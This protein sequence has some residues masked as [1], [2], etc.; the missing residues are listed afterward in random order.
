[1]GSEIV[2]SVK[3]LCW[4]C[5]FL[6][7]A[8]LAII[9][10]IEDYWVLVIASL[11]LVIPWGIGVRL[12]KPNLITTTIIGFSSLLVIGTFLEIWV[13][14]MVLS[15]LFMI[16]AWDLY[17]FDHRLSSVDE[18]RGGSVLARYHIVRLMIVL[19]IGL[20]LSATSLIFRVELS[21]GLALILSFVVILGLR[22]WILVAARTN[23]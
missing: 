9:Y 19:L 13:G 22:Q 11:L 20:L 17:W 5:F 1:M 8:V 2:R 21:F 14:W 18:I 6:A 7:V 23:E 12:E 10:S 4:V 16:A 3:V 15:E